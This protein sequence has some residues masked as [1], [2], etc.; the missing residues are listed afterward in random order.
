MQKKAPLVII[1][2]LNWG[3]GHATRCVP[4]IQELLEAG[5]R[6]QIVAEGRGADF[7]SN[8]FPQLSI[9]AFPGYEITYPGEGG[10]MMMR[11][12]KNTPGILRG[13]KKENE[14]LQE[15]VAKTG[16]DAVISDNR[17]GMHHPRIP[18]I[19]ITH[20]VN[21]KAPFGES[22]IAVMNQR[23]IRK[24]NECWIP[25]EAGAENLSGDLGHTLRFSYHRRY[26]GALS[27]FTS[28][29]VK[30]EKKFDL[31]LL[32]SGPEPQ[33]T[34]LENLLYEEVKNQMQRKPELKTA[35]VRGMP[36]KPASTSHLPG[37]VMPHA[38][39][40]TLRDIIESSTMIIARPGYST[41]MDLERLGAK[42]AFIPTPGQ[43]EQEYLGHRL[44]DLGIALCMKQG[45]IDLSFAIESSGDYKGFSG[46]PAGSQLRTAVAELCR[47]FQGK[48]EH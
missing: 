20:Q 38:A 41:L 6:V 12:V 36:D 3:M 43:T 17:Y 25:D 16:A 44:M 21:I 45:K 22:L 27:R 47:L 35:W 40:E 48:G 30:K 8:A 14:K 2:P 11:M 15:L 29:G 34:V 26:I 13:I 23:Y 10:N 7:L 31:T 46:K 19:F 39:D 32:L 42:A 18:S 24:F 33:R 5:C 9:E 4:V 37:V 28:S 1:S